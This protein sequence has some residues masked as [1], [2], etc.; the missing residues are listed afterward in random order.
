[1]SG[2]RSSPSAPRPALEALLAGASGDPLRRALMLDALDLRLRPCLS[3]P[4]AAHARLANI[5]GHKLVFLV[6]SPVWHARLRLA[7]PE[8]LHAARSLGLDVSALVVRTASAPLQAPG[9][10]E[11]PAAPMSKAARDALQA[12]L[13]SLREAPGESASPGRSP[14][15]RP[16]RGTD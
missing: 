5:S 3:P 1:M 12:A 6:D 16:G 8:L 4:L 2:V 11:R 7:E 13:D 10:A 9:P 14:R 15:R